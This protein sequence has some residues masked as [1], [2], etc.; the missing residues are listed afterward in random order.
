MKEMRIDR[1]MFKKKIKKSFYEKITR[2][3]N[4]I[5][6]GDCNLTLGNKGSKG[7]CES[8]EELI[9]LIT[10]FELEDLWRRQNAN[11]HLYTHFHGRGNTYS[12]IDRAYTSTNLIVGFKIDH[13]TN[14]FSDHFQTI[15]IKKE[16]ANF[17]KEKS[18]WIL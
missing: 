7:F 15:V 3:N 1:H 10:E 9:S 14:N 17:K 11:G 5:L 4:L 12:H 13:K 6:L 2:K 18:Y 8:Q 16:L